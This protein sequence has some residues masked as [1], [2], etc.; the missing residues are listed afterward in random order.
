[1]IQ[2]QYQIL[3]SDFLASR[4]NA[5]LADEMGL[6]KT[7]QAVCAIDLLGLHKRVDKVLIICPAICRPQWDAQLEHWLMFHNQFPVQQVEKTSDKITGNTIMV[8]Y[9][10]VN[11]LN[12]WVQL[13]AIDWDVIIY[14]EFHYMKSVEAKRTTAI[15]G[16]GGII[17][18]SKHNWFLSGTPVNRP[19]DLF[20]VLCTIARSKL[21]PYDR[22]EIYASQFCGA[23]KDDFGHLK[24]HGNSNE[25]QLADMLSKVMLRRLACDVEPDL[26]EPIL[27]PV[28]LELPDDVQDVY[29]RE[30]DD[31]DI[32][33][34]TST[35]KRSILANLKGGT[36]YE[37]MKNSQ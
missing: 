24:T 34:Y 16:K 15:L 32:V 3:G 13:T 9:N 27:D 28:I 7:G 14:D 2:K 18:K 31:I 22:W 19:A 5:I 6:G 30:V 23:Y 21:K 20:P 36:I 26:G 12:I 29:E 11:D 4:K 37:H 17:T 25:E 35:Q 1:M 33:E 10:L 8:S